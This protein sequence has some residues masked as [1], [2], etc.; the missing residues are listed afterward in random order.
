VRGR[1]TV[2]WAAAPLAALALA[3]PACS[4]Q[5]AGPAA[6]AAA[7]IVSPSPGP[8]ELADD[9][10]DHSCGGTGELAPDG[11]MPAPGAAPAGSFMAAIQRRGYL[12]AGVSRGTFGFG[13]L[14]SATGTPAGYDVDMAREVSRALFGD[15]NHVEY[16]FL[17]TAERIGQLRSGT[18]DIV[19]S[20]MTITCGRWRKV[21]FSSAYYADY[22]EVLV[23]DSSPVQR[24]ADLRGGRVCA[25]NAST[26]IFFLRYR[27]EVP[28]M[29]PVSVP[30]F[31]DCLVGLQRGTVDAIAT[32]EGILR[33]LQLEDPHTR[34]L[35]DRL[36]L[37]PH[38]FAIAL[39][40]KDFVRFANALLDRMR[41][42]GT[43]AALYHRW[44]H[45]RLAMS[46]APPPAS[47]YADRSTSSSCQA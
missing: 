4:G 47:D 16:R 2:R 27:A 46:D 38:G 20:T 8:D 30:D 21:A 39:C 23:P 40:H 22:Q 42:D 26:S 5:G 13:Y 28:G 11:P 35:A 12:I 29:R 14:D 15:P 31:N 3:L 33:G 37:E 6:G 43:W 19:I 1:L 24:F 36:V 17:T 7:P 10:T 25:T 18:V 44:F 34:L 41:A 9:A 32:N 45:D